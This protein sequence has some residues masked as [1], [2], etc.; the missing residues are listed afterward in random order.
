MA[1]AARVAAARAAA[2]K[3]AAERAAAAKAAA[4]KAAEAV[5]AEAVKAAKK[6][7]ILEVKLTIL[8]GLS[9]QIKT[10][11]ILILYVI[12]SNQS[13]CNASRETKEKRLSFQKIDQLNA[14]QKGVLK[15]QH[16]NS[17]IKRLVQSLRG[18]RNLANI[19]ITKLGCAN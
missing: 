13:S 6:N 3:A 1:R 15:N 7:Q 2:E 18:Q 5:R 10:F 16:H 19:L 12:Y 11:C 4:V 14:W 17:L 8:K 9:R